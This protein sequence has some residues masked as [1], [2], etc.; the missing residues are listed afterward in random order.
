MHFPSDYLETVHRGAAVL[1]ALGA[2]LREAAAKQPQTPELWLSV[3]DFEGLS[4]RLVER[5]DWDWRHGFADMMLSPQDCAV[6]DELLAAGHAGPVQ[7]SSEENAALTDLDTFLR[8]YCNR[9]FELEELEDR[10][11]E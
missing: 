10:D 1:R 6:V 7:L 8:Q 3:R 5:T 4:A 11:D 2:R 9:E